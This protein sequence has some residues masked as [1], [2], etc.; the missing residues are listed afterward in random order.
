MR[1]LVA[2]L[3]LCAAAEAQAV[4]DTP[5]R[6]TFIT[7]CVKG[8]GAPDAQAQTKVATLCGCTVDTLAKSVPQDQLYAFSKRPD[9][10]ASV[11]QPIM[12]ACMAAM[13]KQGL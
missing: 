6:N 11:M 8:S 9:K 5:V 10:G 2:I 3:I 12:Q 7:N 4:Y 1:Y 13:K